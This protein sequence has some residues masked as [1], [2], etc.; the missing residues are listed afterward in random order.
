VRETV[1]SIGLSGFGEAL[2][3]RE[4]F[5]EIDPNAVDIYGIPVLRIHMTW[6]ENEK[7]MIPDMAQ[8]AAELLDAAGARNIRPWMVPTG[9]PAWASTKSAPRGW[10]PTLDL[11][12]QS[13]PADARREEP[14]RDGWI[15]LRV[16]RVPEPD[17][18][19]HGARRARLRSPDGGDAARQRHHDMV[20]AGGTPFVDDLEGDGAATM[21]TLM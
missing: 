6:S 18:D 17:A 11:R 14:V 7:A 21:L 15:V 20:R 8:S 2:A 13:V 10:A 19:D 3:R 1:T 16:V 12:A 9:S 5:V 4:N